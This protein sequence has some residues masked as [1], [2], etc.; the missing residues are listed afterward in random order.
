VRES[1][2]KIN[3]QQHKY[4]SLKDQ[5][6]ERYR[7]VEKAVRKYE[8]RVGQNLSKNQEFLRRTSELKVMEKEFN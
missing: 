4:C 2:S 1:I 8:F 5:Y 3:Q 6:E 7:A